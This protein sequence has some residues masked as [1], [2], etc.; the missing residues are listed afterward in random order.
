MMVV[1]ELTCPYCNARLTAGGAVAGDER[2]TCPRCGERLPLALSAQLSSASP[3]VPEP[4]APTTAQAPGK[5]KT[6]AVILAIMGAMAAL[7]TAFAFVT[8]DFRRQNDYRTQKKTEPG[9]VTPAAEAS[10]LGFL[11]ARCNVVAALHVS[12]LLKQPATRKLL[13]EP[14]L[15]ALAPSLTRWTGLA[16]ADIDQITA[17]AE[18]KSK[19]PQLTVILQTRQPYVPGSITA[20][21]APA[22]ATNHRQKP[23]V[24]FSIQPAGEG[25][26]WC[27]SD[28]ILVLVLALDAVTIDDLDA[29]PSRPRPGGEGL[30]APLRS[31]LA[32]RLPANSALWLAA[33]FDEF[34]AVGDLLAFNANKHELLESLLRMR[35]WVVSVQPH[36]NPTLTAHFFTGAAEASERLQMLLEARRWDGAASYK[37]AGPPPDAD[38]QDQWVSL[39]ARGDLARWLGQWSK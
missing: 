9:L 2:A 19:L 1:P 28:R 6:L 38:V 3:S 29:V 26:L 39:Q 10:L 8:R 34:P 32:E 18:I 5:R 13:D 4:A 31:A 20:A 24:R 22:Q 36:E 30:A 37:V 14:P 25:L 17:G 21:L 12:E 23:L 33:H 35:T 27:H 15:G 16:V 7:A 11:P